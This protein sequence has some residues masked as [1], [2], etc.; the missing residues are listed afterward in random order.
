MGHFLSFPDFL[1]FLSCLYCH[2]S[3]FLIYWV[4]PPCPILVKVFSPYSIS[5]FLEPLTS[6]LK[7][8]FLFFKGWG[9]SPISCTVV[10]L[11]LTD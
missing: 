1:H 6:D 9:Y 10:V 5:E 3:S 7:A 4:N 11:V 8:D 2:T